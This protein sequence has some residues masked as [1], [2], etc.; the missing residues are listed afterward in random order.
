MRSLRLKLATVGSLGLA[1]AAVLAAGGESWEYAMTVE[2]GGM[3][4]PLPPSTICTRPGQGDTP[5]VERNCEIKERK[6]SGATT[7]FRI[8]CGPPEP[9]ELKGD[10]RRKDDLV[11]G[12]YTMTKDGESMIVT[13]IGS[14]KGSCD[15]SKPPE[16]A[17][18]K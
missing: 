10:F 14:K 7:T 2:A 6:L 13:A 17:G 12:R 11:E 18:M 1:A 5:P 8:V 15:P 16:P 3:K 9:G 4:M